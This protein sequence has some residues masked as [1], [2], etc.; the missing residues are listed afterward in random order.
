MNPFRPAGD[1][2]CPVCRHRIVRHGDDGCQVE[3]CDCTTSA[4]AVESPHAR[5]R[6]RDGTSILLGEYINGWDS[7]SCLA[8]G[9]RTFNEGAVCCG[10]PM[11][12]VRVTITHREVTP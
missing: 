7:N 1:S 4:P 5:A 6:L 9:S 8:C 10:Q 11:V 2:R 3:G 12:P